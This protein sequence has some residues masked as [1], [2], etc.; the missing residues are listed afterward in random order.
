MARTAGSATARVAAKTRKGNVGD[1]W[2]PIDLRKDSAAYNTAPRYGVMSGVLF[3]GAEWIRPLLLDWHQGIDGTP[4]T[5]RFDVFVRG[6]GT[7]EGH[8]V[9]EVPFEGSG[10]CPC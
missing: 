7:T 1:P 10:G 6:Q 3:D 9:R 5:A 8:H 2:I 4:M